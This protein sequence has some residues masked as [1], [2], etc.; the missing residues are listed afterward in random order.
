MPLM[1]QCFCYGICR[2]CQEFVVD[3]MP[4]LEP[5]VIE[6]SVVFERLQNR[7]IEG[8]LKH[9]PICWFMHNAMSN[10][11][12]SNWPSMYVII[13]NGWYIFGSNTFCSPDSGR[14]RIRC[15]FRR[16]NHVHLWDCISPP[17]PI[18]GKK[19]SL[20]LHFGPG[21]LRMPRALCLPL[22]TQPR[23]TKGHLPPEMPVQPLIWQSVKQTAECYVKFA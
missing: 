17:R 22:S 8:T 6:Q 7:I 23:S 13:Q 18:P 4:W 9:T 15:R 20:C 12:K 2:L 14:L 5:D 1:L 21:P 19:T 11:Y 3:F 16:Q 10:I